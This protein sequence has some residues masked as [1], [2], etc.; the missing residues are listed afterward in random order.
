[1]KLTGNNKIRSLLLFWQ[2]CNDKEIINLGMSIEW[3]LKHPSSRNGLWK[4]H[5]LQE[6]QTRQHLPRCGR[7]RYKQAPTS[8]GIEPMSFSKTAE[9]ELIKECPLP[10]EKETFHVCPV[11]FRIAIHQW[12][13]VTHSFSFLW[14]CLFV[15][16]VFGGGGTKI[17]YFRP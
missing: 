13:C 9:L 2:S 1:M 6:R 4:L 16:I 11:N 8:Q 3:A 17:C 12:P 7:G 15:L 14:E 5:L 10:P